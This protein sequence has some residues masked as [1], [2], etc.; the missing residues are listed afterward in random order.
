MPSGSKGRR[1][2][3][4]FVEPAQDELLRLVCVIA[5][6]DQQD[7]IADAVAKAIW[8][9]VAE[10]DFKAKLREHRARL[11]ELEAGHG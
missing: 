6:V 4:F 8:D 11:D 5:G 1:Q 7:F 9:A 10:P 2:K 3:N